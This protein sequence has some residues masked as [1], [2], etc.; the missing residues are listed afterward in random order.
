MSTS[1]WR[2]TTRSSR[3]SRRFDIRRDSPMKLSCDRRQHRR[4]VGA[5]HAWRPGK[6]TKIGGEVEVVAH[7]QLGV[8]ADVVDALGRAP[9][10]C[11]DAGTR[12]VVGMDVVGV[13]VVLAHQHRR[14]AR[15]ALA[16]MARPVG[17]VDARH[18]QH[19]HPHAARASEVAHSRL[20]IGA[21]KCTVR[22]RPHRAGLVDARSAAI[23]IHAAG[24]GVDQPPYRARPR[25]RLQQVARAGI[26]RPVRLRR[27][28]VEHRVGERSQTPQA[29]GVV[30]IADERHGPG[31]PKCR[32]PRRPTW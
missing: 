18:A 19:A 22:L 6:T 2:S 14:A 25:K 1:G 31:G 24:A 26:V 4:C 20:G 11:R 27:R 17:G 32:A 12:Q 30:E 16:R 9:V 15:E 8:V 3:F 28:Q 21:A 29:G 13:D 7:A 23:A 5:R 10:Q